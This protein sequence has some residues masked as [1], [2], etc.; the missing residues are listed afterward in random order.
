MVLPDK[1]YEGLVD[2]EGWHL[3]E[4]ENVWYPKEYRF[5]YAPTKELNEILKGLAMSN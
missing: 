4:T 1:P 5:D 3:V 2:P